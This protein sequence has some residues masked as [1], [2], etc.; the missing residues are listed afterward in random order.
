MFFFSAKG[1]ILGFIYCFF[2]FLGYKSVLK[3]CYEDFSLQK[4]QKITVL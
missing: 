4:A 3:Y 2:D 1:R